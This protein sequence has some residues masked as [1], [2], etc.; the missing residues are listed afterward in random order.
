MV[1]YIEVP[2]RSLSGPILGSYCVVDD[3]PRDFLEPNALRN[4]QEVTS[5]ISKYLD[6]KRVEEGRMRSEKMMNGLR[7]FVGSHHS[8][9]TD[10]ANT[11]GPFS[12]DIF[13]ERAPN[14]SHHSPSM[15]FR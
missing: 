12:L 11:K 9:A 10:C 2:L 15:L 1:S 6:L 4:I 3:K 14:V 5:A 8:T 13:E 7:Q